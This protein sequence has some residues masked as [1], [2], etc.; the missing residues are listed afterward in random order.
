M[1]L[2]KIALVLTI[3]IATII[4]ASIFNVT[5]ATTNTNNVRSRYLTIKKLRASGYGYEA[6]G[7]SIWKICNQ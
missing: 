1:K 7:K 4:V 5:Y 6:I 2:R 3:I